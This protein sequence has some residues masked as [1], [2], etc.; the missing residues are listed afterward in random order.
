MIGKYLKTS[1]KCIIFVILPDSHQLGVYNKEK[2]LVVLAKLLGY[3][4]HTPYLH[5]MVCYMSECE[6]LE[7]SC[8]QFYLKVLLINPSIEPGKY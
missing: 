1:R 6:I 7:Q 2:Y 8:S 5:Y 4:N 3:A